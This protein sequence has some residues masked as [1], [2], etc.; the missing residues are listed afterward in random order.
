MDVLH[1]KEIHGGEKSW[2]TRQTS[3]TCTEV[4]PRYSELCRDGISM[5]VHV[6]TG[7]PLYTHA[8]IQECKTGVCLCVHPCLLDI[9]RQLPCTYEAR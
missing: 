9:S 8:D 7:L 5:Y 4:V 2:L 1:R 3:G 6:S